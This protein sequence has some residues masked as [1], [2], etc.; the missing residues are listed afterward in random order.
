MEENFF[1][2][3]KWGQTWAIRYEGSTDLFYAITWLGEDDLF[4][5]VSLTSSHLNRIF[6]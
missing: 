4:R 6:Q 1:S 3:E 2:H 5:A